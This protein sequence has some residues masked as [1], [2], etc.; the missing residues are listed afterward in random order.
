MPCPLQAP[1]ET[2]YAPALNISLGYKRWWGNWSE[3][4]VID[5]MAR[6]SVLCVCLGTMWSFNAASDAVL[7]QENL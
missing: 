7:E 4:R 3:A 5:F 2:R 1:T 6:T